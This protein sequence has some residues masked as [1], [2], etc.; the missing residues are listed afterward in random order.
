MLLSWA[1]VVLGTAKHDVVYCFVVRLIFGRSCKYWIV[2][3]ENDDVFVSNQAEAFTDSVTLTG[4]DEVFTAELDK[5]AGLSCDLNRM[6]PAPV[7]EVGNEWCLPP[8]DT[9]AFSALW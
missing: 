6:R 1:F 4:A 5:V 8:I 2:I 7:S 9:R 3:V